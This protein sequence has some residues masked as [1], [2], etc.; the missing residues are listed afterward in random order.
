MASCHMSLS[1][2]QSV[3]NGI[4]KSRGLHN[5]SPAS[6]MIT[7]QSG[8]H[9]ESRA[10]ARGSMRECPGRCSCDRLRS[11]G[12]AYARA[13]RVDGNALSK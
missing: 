13:R 3:D 4:L 12:G 1:L 11:E 2:K 9:H 7:L 5:E 6:G 10:G 8:G